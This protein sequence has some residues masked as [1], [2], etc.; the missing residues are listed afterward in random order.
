MEQAERSASQKLLFGGVFGGRITDLLS[1]DG[2]RCSDLQ[3]K[4]P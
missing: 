2:N 4:Q 3:D 1:I